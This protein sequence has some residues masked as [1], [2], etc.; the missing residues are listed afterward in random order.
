MGFKIFVQHQVWSTVYSE[1]YKLVLTC[2]PDPECW[3]VGFRSSKQNACFRGTVKGYI[4]KLTILQPAC[5]SR[6]QF[7]TAC[8]ED[9]EGKVVFILWDSSVDFSS[10]PGDL[11]ACR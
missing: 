3:L 9:A 2:I 6:M 10:G 5:S 8:C 11:L 7:R 4:S 1:I